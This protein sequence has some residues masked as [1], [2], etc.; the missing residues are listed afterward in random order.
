MSRKTQQ[1][2][3]RKV[4]SREIVHHWTVLSSLEERQHMQ[5]RGNFWMQE[6]MALLRRIHAM[7][8]SAWGNRRCADLTMN[9]GRHSR[10]DVGQH[11]ALLPLRYAS[12]R[13]NGDE[14]TNSWQFTG[15]ETE[16]LFWMPVESTATV[17]V[18][19]ASEALIHNWQH[20]CR[21]DS[22]ALFLAITKELW[23]MVGR[24]NSSSWT[25]W[26]IKKTEQEDMS[27]L[28][29]QVY[30]AGMWWASLFRLPSFLSRG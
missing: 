18:E 23:D 3:E 21:S 30:L 24:L 2:M 14:V 9:W 25:E 28:R 11:I 12:K 5:C 19:E 13:L 4:K 29:E 16:M 27:V 1:H 8:N 6:N 22:P 7:V 26:M 20:I 10:R 17:N 15:R